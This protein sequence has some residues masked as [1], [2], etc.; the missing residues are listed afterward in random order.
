MSYPIPRV[1]LCYRKERE[2][3]KEKE[4]I[5]RKDRSEAEEE[6]GRKSS[7]LKWH[8]SPLLV[9]LP[10]ST[11]YFLLFYTFLKKFFLFTTLGSISSFRLW[12]S[13]TSLCLSCAL[14]SHF[15]FISVIRQLQWPFESDREENEARM[16]VFSSSSS[17][18]KQPSGG[19]TAQSWHTHPGLIL[20]ASL[21]TC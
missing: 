17:S 20:Y 13:L 19:Q 11:N 2:G 7:S 10:T 16:A 6:G 14:L 21:L 18:F 1:S 5:E 8:S 4:E 15:L 9:S 3:T 12:V